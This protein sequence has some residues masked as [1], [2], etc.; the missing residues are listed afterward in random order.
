MQGI[1]T[2]GFGEDGV[3]VHHRIQGTEGTIEVTP[4]GSPQAR[5]RED[6]GDWEP[7]VDG[8]ENSSAVPP[9][10]DHVVECLNDGTEPEISARHALAVTEIIFA[11]WESSRRRGRVDLPLDIDDNPLES[12]VESGAL[13]PEPADGD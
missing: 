11:A 12:M 3:G 13:T 7:L 4:W 1:A 9:A 5:I 10:I 8:V 2:T 6:G